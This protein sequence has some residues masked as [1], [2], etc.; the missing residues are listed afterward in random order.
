MYK[1][2]LIALLIITS[3]SIAA[4]EWSWVEY[5]KSAT[6]DDDS[7]LTLYADL[8]KIRIDG[9]LRKVWQL[10]DMSQ[11]SSAKVLSK[12]YQEEFNCKEETQRVLY[13]RIYYGNMGSGQSS[14]IPL[15]KEEK[16]SRPILPN[17]V[18]SEALKVVCGLRQ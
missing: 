9:H 16:E 7:V 5:G 12:M 17:T 10:A 6:K 4:N 14:V 13:T 11:P 1:A 2:I 18:Q 15:T 3:E 8:S